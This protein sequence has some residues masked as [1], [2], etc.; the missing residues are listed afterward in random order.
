MSRNHFLMKSRRWLAV[1]R[2]A[3]ERD[4]Y[5]CRKC[6]SPGALEGHHEPPLKHGGDPYDLS[7]ILTYCRGCHIEHHRLDDETPGRA[8]WRAFLE[9]F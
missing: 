3:F 6:G 5:R 2:A 7:G 1:R 4:G 8:E 9:S